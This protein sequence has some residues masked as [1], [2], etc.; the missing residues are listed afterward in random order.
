MYKDRTIQELVCYL[1]YPIEFIEVDVVEKF[2]LRT[3]HVSL[4]QS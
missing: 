3:I 2:N 4:R 1:V